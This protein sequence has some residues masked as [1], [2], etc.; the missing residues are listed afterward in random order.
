[1]AGTTIV[2]RQLDPTSYPSMGRNRII[3]GEMAIDQANG[4]TALTVNNSVRFWTVDGRWFGFGQT[5]PGVFTLQRLTATPPTGFSY[6]LRAKTTTADAALTGNFYI[7]RLTM[8]GLLTRDFLWGSSSA[9]PVTLSFW[10]RGS[11]AGTYAVTI[12]NTAATRFYVATYTINSANAWEYKTI[13]IPGE[14]TGAWPVDGNDSFVITIPIG[15]APFRQTSTVNQWVVGGSELDQA[16]GAVNIMQTLNATLDITGVQLER[17]AGATPFEYRPFPIELQLCQ[18]Y[19]EKSY[20]LDTVPGTNTNLGM[21]TAVT[22]Q[23]GTNNRLSQVIKFKMTKRIVPTSLTLYSPTG[24]Q[25]S[26][27]WISTA[28]VTTD[29][30]TNTSSVGVYTHGFGIAQT[31]TNSDQSAYG[32]WVADARL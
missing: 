2:A 11:I 10:I 26:W 27:T 28:G 20:D 17:G 1:M 21:D 29:R 32:H 3:N 30:V 23:F 6:Y 12:F 7:L 14:T 4:G 9:S 5:S 24:T 15:V 31:I 16:T 18:R 25:G 22:A 8:E 19:L 13:V